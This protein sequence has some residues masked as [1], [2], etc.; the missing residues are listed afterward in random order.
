[1]VSDELGDGISASESGPC[2]HT[3]RCVESKPPKKSGAWQRV[4][5]CLPT[6]FPP[7][8]RSASCASESEVSDQRRASRKKSPPT[9][10]FDGGD[11]EDPTAAAATEGSGR[12]IK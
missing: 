11:G 8:F 4:E 1:M 12:K 3:L 9:R 2:A 5:S 10:R 6:G 7:T